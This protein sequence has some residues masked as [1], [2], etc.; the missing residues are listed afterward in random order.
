[1]LAYTTQM[2]SAYTRGVGFT[3]GGVPN[4]D[5][6]SVILSAAARI[7]ANPR[8]FVGSQTEGQESV[9]YRAAWNGF[10]VAETFALRRYR[11]TAE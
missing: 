4:A 2:V 1:M 3:S 10:N 11:K 6:W 7:W 5:L 8:Q 9:D